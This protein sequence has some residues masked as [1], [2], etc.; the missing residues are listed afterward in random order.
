MQ[1]L[2]INCKWCL[3]DG[4]SPE[5][6]KCNAPQNPLGKPQRDFVTG[7]NPKPVHET[8]YCATHR[9]YDWFWARVLNVCGREG[10]WFVAK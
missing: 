10:R 1:R 3:N 8:K 4:S 5:Y 9:H 7:I 2:C 6:A